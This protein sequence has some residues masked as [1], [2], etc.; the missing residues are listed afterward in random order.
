MRPSVRGSNALSTL[1]AKKE[2]LDPTFLGENLDKLFAYVDKV[3]M[4]IAALNLPEK[5][6]DHD[7]FQAMSKQLDGILEATVDAS[8][9][10]MSAVEK[11]NE[12]IEKLQALVSDEEQSAVIDE[13]VDGHNEIFEACAFQDLTGQ[14][15][16]Q[17]SKSVSYVEERV[18]ALHEL[19]GKDELDKIELEPEKELTEDEK[20]LNGPQA[21]AEALNQADI[22]AMFD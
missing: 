4:E 2:N 20:L 3:R 21:K 22:D 14:R 6:S 1:S 12:A 10:I 5:D 17:L 18:S 8:D 7:R 11:N 15:V 13:I 19:W 16:T 9:K